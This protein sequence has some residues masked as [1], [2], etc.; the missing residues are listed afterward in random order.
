MQRTFYFILTKQ[1]LMN[2]SKHI[3]IILISVFFLTQ[4]NAQN[5]Q[6]QGL[7]ASDTIWHA[8]TLEIT[9]EV[10]IDSNVTLIINPGTF[11]HING[12]YAIWSYGN[13]NAIGTEAD[14]IVFTHLDTTMHNDTSTIEGGWHGIRLLPRS[15]QDTSIFKYC[16]ISNGK[17]VV[18]GSWWSIQIPENQ[19]GNIYGK[20][21]GSIIMSNCAIHNGRVK[22]DGGGIFLENGESVIIEQCDFSYNHAYN[23]Y[24]GGAFISKVELVD[25][26]DC[27]FYKN[28]CYHKDAI[29]EG[30]QG[31]GI[32]VQYSLGYNAIASIENNRIFN[33]KSATG[34]IYECYYHSVIIGN[35]IC[36]NYGSGIMNAPFDNHALYINN[37]IVNNVG[38]IYSGIITT[39]SDIELINNIV[40][41]NYAYPNYPIDQIFYYNGAVPQP[42]VSYCNVEFG[43]EGEGNIDS[44]PLFVNP[45]SGIG[46]AYDALNADWAL[47]DNSKSIN[48]GTLDTTGLCLP[49]HDLAGNPRVFGNRIDIGAYENQH[50]YVKVNNAPIGESL[51]I[52]PN[53]GT[54]ELYISLTPEMKGY[55]FDMFNSQGKIIMHHKLENLNSSFST[56]KLSS[57][58]YHYRIY[59]DRKQVIKNS[60]WIKF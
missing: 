37:T 45:T 27:L 40:R 11:I 15:T 23:L 19:G 29:G 26:R 1:K 28:T 2:I 48:V 16:K 54:K 9:G 6:F 43:F 53:P 4:T 34:S 41:N 39:S 47:L 49:Y 50:I 18:P 24:G 38:S 7:I 55:F 42:I 30:G 25:I 20:S 44:D 58:A 10:I 36:N 13:I 22:S 32:A 60:T 52:Y 12:Y 35:I 8:D 33:N 3:Y 17:S 21:F 31:A 57:G 56:E 46:L 5:F 51:S 59:N 14:S